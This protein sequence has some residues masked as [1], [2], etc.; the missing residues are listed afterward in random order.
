MFAKYLNTYHSTYTHKHTQGSY[1]PLVLLPLSRSHISFCLR[2]TNPSFTHNLLFSPSVYRKYLSPLL[3]SL[4]FLFFLY[5]PS[6]LLPKLSLSFD[7]HHIILEA[8]NVKFRQLFGSQLLIHF[9]R[10]K[11]SLRT[12]FLVMRCLGHSVRKHLTHDVQCVVNLYIFAHIRGDMW[13][14]YKC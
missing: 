4:L 6:I 7:S 1:C 10:N 3:I 5:T 2:L 9:S 14:K 11:S 13:V 8:F 12:V